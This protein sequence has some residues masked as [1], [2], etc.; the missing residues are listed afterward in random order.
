MAENEKSTITVDEK[1]ILDMSEKIRQNIREDNRF[2]RSLSEFLNVSERKSEYILVGST[3]N[4]L[5]I[6]GANKSLDVVI[7]PKT[8][9]KCMSDSD[10]KYHGHG[11]SQ[12]IIQ[13][14]PSELRN[15]VMIFKGSVS[16]SLVAITG[17]KDNQNREIMIAVSLSEK[18]GF[19]EVNRISSAYGRN[20]FKNYIKQ[21][22]E[23]GNLIACNKEKAE[24]MLH[25]AGL[26]LPLENTFLSFDN[27]IAYSL[28]NVNT[29]KVRK[30][31]IQRLDINPKGSLLGKLRNNEKKVQSAEKLPVKT[32]Q[33]E[34]IE[35]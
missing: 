17:F 18:K 9:V 2:Y 14:L 26:Q 25:S 11:L 23:C 27:S 13:Q 24:K 6:A 33:K 3:S 1:D 10:K 21:Q 32:S 31:D 34:T 8:I 15:P 7:S 35:K 4:A 12:Y 30:L 5:A 19:S 29:Q 16:N 28:K 22:I 20:N